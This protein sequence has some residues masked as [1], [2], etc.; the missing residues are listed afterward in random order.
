MPVDPSNIVTKE[1][2][3]AVIADLIKESPDHVVLLESPASDIR[4]AEELLAIKEGTLPNTICRFSKGEERC[5]N[6]GRNLSVLDLIKTAL[7]VHSKEFLN[8]II[9]GNEYIQTRYTRDMEKAPTCYDCGK[10]GLGPLSYGQDQGRYSCYWGLLGP[11]WSYD[12]S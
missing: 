9:F 12:G 10:K 8:D 5:P 11:G 1:H 7:E 4:R 2:H 6:C 3:D